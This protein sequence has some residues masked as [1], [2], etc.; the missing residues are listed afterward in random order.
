MKA[1]NP[2][3]NVP[4]L[5]HTDDSDSRS[6]TGFAGVGHVGSDH[7]QDRLFTKTT[8]LLITTAEQSY[9]SSATVVPGSSREKKVMDSAGRWSTFAAIGVN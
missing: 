8:L 3:K 2:S 7:I 4:D 9:N 5:A 6:D 1:A